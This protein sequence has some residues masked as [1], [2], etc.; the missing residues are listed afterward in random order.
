MRSHVE[1]TLV[2]R[3]RLGGRGGEAEARV[4]RVEDG[5][6]LAKE[7]VAEDPQRAGGRRHVHGR[8]AEQ[9]RRLAKRLGRARP[10]RVRKGQ[11]APLGGWP[12]GWS[13]GGA[14]RG[15]PQP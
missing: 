6:V 11:A 15:A 4:A 10:G 12:S 7:D 8:H 14:R 5:E 9:A 13:E 2:G 3:G 1:C